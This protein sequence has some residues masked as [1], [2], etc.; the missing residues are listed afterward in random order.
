MPTSPRGPAGKMR[1]LECAGSSYRCPSAAASGAV[2]ASNERLSLMRLFSWMLRRQLQFH[3]L[4]DRRKEGKTP[5]KAFLRLDEVVLSSRL[6][7]LRLHSPNVFC[8]LFPRWIRKINPTELLEFIV[9]P[10]TI[11]QKDWSD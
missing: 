6:T 10:R 5:P 2:V 11:L 7:K 4:L 8:E 3:G 9:L 1:P